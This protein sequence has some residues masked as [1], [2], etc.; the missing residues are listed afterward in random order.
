MDNRPTNAYI[1]P[2]LSETGGVFGGMLKMR[3]LVEAGFCLGGIV[4]IGKI[5]SLIIPSVITTIVFL[6]IGIVVGLIAVT[7]VRGEPLSVFIL[8]V[9]IYRR[10]R[11][12]C[13]LRMPMPMEYEAENNSDEDTAEGY[14]NKKGGKVSKF[15]QLLMNLLD[16]NKKRNDGE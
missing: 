10:V 3:N 13:Q 15:D 8:N 16:G 12:Y 1:P 7:G 14:S 4:L 11:G 2:N 9:I 5:V 6:V